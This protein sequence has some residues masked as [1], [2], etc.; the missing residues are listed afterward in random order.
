[1]TSPQKKFGWLLLTF[2]GVWEA[3]CRGSVVS[4]NMWF[5]AENVVLMGNPYVLEGSSPA[6][7]VV[8]VAKW[9][10]YSAKRPGFGKKAYFQR[11]KPP[12][13]WS[14]WYFSS[15]TCKTYTF[16]KKNWA[17]TAIP[18]PSSGQTDLQTPIWGRS[19]QLDDQIRNPNV[20]N[21]DHLVGRPTTCHM[22]STMTMLIT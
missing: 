14:N 12:K 11:V 9:T 7:N 17:K 13:I 20:N 5:A 16:W 6:E 10:T 18:A 15:V 8:Q 3:F 2:G 1:M 4:R 21:R 19:Y 22:E